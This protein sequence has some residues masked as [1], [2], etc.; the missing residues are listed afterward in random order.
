MASA[1]QCPAA[2]IQLDYR[3]WL[4]QVD[5]ALQSM[6]MQ[7]EA[8]QS[9]WPYDF[10]ADFTKGLAPPEAASRAHD[11]WWRRLQSEAWT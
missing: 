5:A 3:T 1:K 7:I 9:N 4:S 2:A 10:R 8:W 11:F 6:H